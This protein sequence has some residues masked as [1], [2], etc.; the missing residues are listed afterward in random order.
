MKKPSSKEVAFSYDYA[1]G[2]TPK[3]ERHVNSLQVGCQGTKYHKSKRI[4]ITF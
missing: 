4:V 2:V 3:P 1:H